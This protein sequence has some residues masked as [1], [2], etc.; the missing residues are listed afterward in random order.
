MNSAFE[1]EAIVYEENSAK[2]MERVNNE[3]SRVHVGSL[4]AIASEIPAFNCNLIIVADGSFPQEYGGI[5]F[6]K[7]TQ[8][9]KHKMSLPTIIAFRTMYKKYDQKYRPHLVDLA[10]SNDNSV[11]KPLKF[12][13][14]ASAFYAIAIGFAAATFALA[15][16]LICKKMQRVKNDHI[17]SN[18]NRLERIIFSTW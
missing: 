3:S 14:T 17:P 6:S 5:L 7:S 11:K 4:Y 9:W 15:V 1:K 10:C 8:K 13:Q 18:I 16:E 12:Q 2:A